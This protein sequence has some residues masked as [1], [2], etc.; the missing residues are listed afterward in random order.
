[1]SVFAEIADAIVDHAE[2]M[3]RVDA[4]RLDA[5]AF[6]AAAQ[7]HVHAIRVLAAPHVDPLAD[8]AFFKA[9]KAATLRAPGVFVH[10]PDGVV[11]FLVDTPRGQRRFELWNARELREGG[12]D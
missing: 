11:E 8:R 10:I 3:T 1:M 5:A 2:A 12:R 7:E 6:E 9:L 4:R